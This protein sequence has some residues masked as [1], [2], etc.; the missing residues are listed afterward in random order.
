MTGAGFGWDRSFFL[1]EFFEKIIVFHKLFIYLPKQHKTIRYDH[2][3]E[4]T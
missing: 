1:Y 3:V 2:L 4:F